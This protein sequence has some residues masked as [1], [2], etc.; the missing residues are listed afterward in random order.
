[1]FQLVDVTADGHLTAV[2][3]SIP[4]QQVPRL[5]GRWDVQLVDVTAD[6]QLTAADLSILEQ[7]VPRLLGRWRAKKK[8]QKEG[9]A[10]VVA[11][12]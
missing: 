5:L 8:N 12:V 4:E 7:Q 6:G 1:M 2:D 9:K 11:A 10:K 3:L